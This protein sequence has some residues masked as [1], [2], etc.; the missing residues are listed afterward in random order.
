MS[1]AVSIW[2]LSLVCVG[3]SKSAWIG[4]LMCRSSRWWVCRCDWLRRR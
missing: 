1:L 3:G 2:W 4:G